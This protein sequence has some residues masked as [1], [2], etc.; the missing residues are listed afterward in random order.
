MPAKLMRGSCCCTTHQ[1]GQ[2]DTE[3]FCDDRI[4]VLVLHDTLVTLFLHHLCLDIVM[5]D[6]E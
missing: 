3:L 6:L 1:P 2:S 5:S 4:Y